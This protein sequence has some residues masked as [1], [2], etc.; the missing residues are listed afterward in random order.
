MTVW[1]VPGRETRDGLLRRAATWGVAAFVFT[2]PFEEIV[3]IPG[4]GS[5]TR[6]VGLAAIVLGLVALFEGGERVRLRRPTAFVLLTAVY[7]VWNLATW[8]W[9]Y[10]PAATQRTVFT[11]A[12]L[13]AFV[14][15]M[16]EFCRDQR[17]LLRLMQAFVLGNYVAFGITAT[18]VLVVADGAFRE[19]GRFNANEFSILLALGI[20]MAALLLGQTRG[21]WLYAAN[22]AYPVVATFGVVLG[23]S[24]GGLIVCLVA[25]TVV[26]FAMAHLGPARRVSLLLAAVAAAWFSFAFAP[27]LV[28]DL[29]RNVERLQGTADELATGTL[30]GRTTIWSETLEVFEASPVV[31][32][33]AGATRFALAESDLGRVKAVH[34][35]FLSV[36]S[37]SG[38]IGLGLLAA[39]IALAFAGAALAPRAL[40]P[41]LL[42]LG[43]AMLVAMM[44]ANLEARKATWF[45]WVLLAAHRPVSLTWR[46]EGRP[47]PLRQFR[48]RGSPYHAAKGA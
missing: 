48:V 5:T 17:G 12:Q 26:P 47:T 39:L 42:V 4:L 32:I 33:G 41:F 22:A 8:F 10:E 3:T 20:P 6:L 35:A 46:S 38:L 16:T 9:S 23:A 21:G 36:A 27:V 2:I 7:V 31:G 30:T 28:P 37:G 19:I 34:N 13:L 29:V 45:V 44:P 43:A 24:R 40:R 18:N 11:L 14:W 25:L 15:L 1:T